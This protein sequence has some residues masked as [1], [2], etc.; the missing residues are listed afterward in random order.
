MMSIITQQGSLSVSNER[1]PPES[2]STCAVSLHYLSIDTQPIT[3]HD[4]EQ[5]TE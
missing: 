1:E 3:L 4:S 2:K 5:L